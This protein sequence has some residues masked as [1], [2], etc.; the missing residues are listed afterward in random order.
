M[1]V[2]FCGFFGWTELQGLEVLQKQIRAESFQTTK[3]KIVAGEVETYHGT[4]STQYI[5]RLSY[6]YEV[7]GV[8]YKSRRYRYRRYSF[9]TMQ[10]A[11]S[12]VQ[13]HAVGSEIEVHYNPAQPADALLAPGVM[14]QD[15]S[16]LFLVVMPL[17]FFAWVAW[18]AMAGIQWP[19]AGMA[20]AGGQKIIADGT[21]IR[22]RLPP[23]K[24]GYLASI[25][26]SFLA[27]FAGL[28]VAKTSTEPI[29]AGKIALGLLIAIPGAVFAWDWKLITSGKQDLVID[30]ASR[31]IE[32]P[33]TFKRKSPV[34]MPISEVTGIT[35]EKVAHR[36]RYG[37][38][39]TFAPTLVLRDG[40][41]QRLTDLDSNRAEAFVTWLS[42][43]LGVR[44]SGDQA[45]TPQ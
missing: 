19:G 14:N 5:P 34:M 26:F 8:K 7:N 16:L 2:A 40:S 11:E 18:S 24:P 43:K 42:E 37:V 20:P 38:R 41:T 45:N 12:V 21:R 3:G 25:T 1:F 23:R 22:V 13:A 39:Y 15:I 4:K 29:L 44:Y 33:Q 28:W 30:D 36:G 6:A 32:L 31:T 9:Y 27:L 10:E 17:G 35:L